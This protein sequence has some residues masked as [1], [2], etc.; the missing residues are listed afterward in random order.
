MLKSIFSYYISNIDDPD[1]RQ[2]FEDTL[3]M[4]QTRVKRTAEILKMEG[5]PLPKGFGDEDVDT[6]APR[7]YTDLFYYYYNLKMLQ[8]G[9]Q[10]SSMNLS[11]ATRSDIRDFY[12]KSLE[13]TARYFNRFSDLMLVKGIYIR[14]PYI[15]T[16]KEQDVVEKQNFLQ[17]FLG[18][19][20]I[21]LADEIEQLFLSYWNN[22]IGA[23]LLT[24][25]KQVA[26]S[27]QVRAY[28][29]RGA[30]IAKK[31]VEIFTTIMGKE[32]IPV[33]SHAG[34]FVTDST[35]PPFSDRLMMYHVVVLSGIGV[36]NYA[37]AMVSSMRHDLSAT[38]VRLIG[39]AANYVEDGLNIMIENGW[40][41]EP[42]RVVDR[43][44]L[45]NEAKH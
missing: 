21:L 30:N 35:T 4:L 16:F 6:G 17:G 10:L 26:R 27:G 32:D 24:G 31:H 45:V 14:P 7:L 25:F 37:M 40:F 13:S 22:T 5:Q 33:T 3:S 44:E 36:G 1:L 11:N 34:E 19:R 41:E 39:E 20:R 38:F 18:E 23:A 15:N 42:P 43:R 12:T 28:M 2:P 8:I 9:N 29:A